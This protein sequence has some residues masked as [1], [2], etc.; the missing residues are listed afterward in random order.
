[1]IT[2]YV[3]GWW[4]AERQLTIVPRPKFPFKNY[5]TPDTYSRVY[6]RD[7]EARPNNFIPRVGLRF[8]WTNLLT[9][10][11]EFDHANWTKTNLTVTPNNG[12][13]PDGQ[14][15]LDTLLETVTNA[16]HS[17]AQPAVVAA[18]AQEASVFA[19]A[20]L[21]R[22]WVRLAFVDSA[23]AT[24][25]AFFDVLSGIAVNPSAG[26]LAKIVALGNGQFRCVIRFT[27]AAGAGTFK[28]NV[29]TDSSTI[30]YAGTTLAGIYL[31]GAQVMA[32]LETP[33]V[34]TTT[35]ARAV[36]APERDQRDPLAYLVSEED[37][38]PQSSENHIARRVFAR[39]P[40]QQTISGS[41]W[42]TKPTIPGTF[43]QVY[44]S[45]VV[46]QPDP[47][48]GS[49]NQYIPQSVTAD[50][51]PAVGGGAP[52][53]GQYTLTFGANTTTPIAYNANAAT[54]QAALNALA[55]ITAQDG[56]TVTG[57]YTT[58]FVVAFNNKASAVANLGSLT[59]AGGTAQA[60]MN[61]NDGNWGQMF[62]ITTTTGQNFT[63]GT[64]T[65]T[66]FGQTTAAIA[67]NANYTTALAA[68]NALSTVV[69]RGGVTTSGQ[70]GS[71]L[72]QT[73]FINWGFTFTPVALI[74]GSATNLVPS[75]GAA[76]SV[77]PSGFYWQR[78]QN[79]SLI[80]GAAPRNITAAAHGITIADS[81][82]VLAGENYYAISP[83]NFTVPDAN[84]IAFSASASAAAIDPA[85]VTLV[86]K[87]SGQPYKAGLKLTRCDRVTDFYLPGVTAGITTPADIPLPT[88]QGDPTSLLAA[89]F[90]GTTSINYEVG[91]LVQWEQT[92]ILQRTITTINAATL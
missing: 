9:K 76:I 7:Y 51:G 21:T 72:T 84:T 92:P 17:V 56:V 11:E 40:R 3:D 14:T 29:A 55:S 81:I 86:G 75:S 41:I 49:Y 35:V 89:I 91:E 79:V 32:G 46:F 39:I 12:T 43:P 4:G 68:I 33:Y 36:S 52:T 26:V 64:F 24:F 69:A 48:V 70:T 42:V 31:W 73:N 18:T 62:V 1:M 8:S 66:M 58:G 61:N 6:E 37:P 67:Y 27:P 30:N 34:A 50:S 90:A 77:T 45:F 53:G 80:A 47:T 74:S 88:Y 71:I 87:K 65:V 13:A 54:V 57:A 63:G 2:P 82:F 38:S 44:G 83:G 19:V 60:S 28:I 10:S 15:T 25:S 78:V 23:A 5:Q 20:G 22:R 16:E 85:T 59:T